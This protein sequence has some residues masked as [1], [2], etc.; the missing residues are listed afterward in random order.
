[1]SNVFAYAASLLPVAPCLGVT[2]AF[3]GIVDR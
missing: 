1:M 3:P 2:D